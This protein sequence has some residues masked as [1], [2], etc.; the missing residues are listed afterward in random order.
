MSSALLCIA[1]G[2]NIS[3][4]NDLGYYNTSCKH[5]SPMVTSATSVL[6]R[7]VFNLGDAGS[8]GVEIGVCS[9]SGCGSDSSSGSI[10]FSGS[11]ADVQVEVV[12]VVALVALGV[13]VVVFVVVAVAVLSSQW[14]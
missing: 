11:G 13:V 5:S 10:S 2:S 6:F 14:R 9:G 7:I 3:S 12:V 1:P 8:I 4:I